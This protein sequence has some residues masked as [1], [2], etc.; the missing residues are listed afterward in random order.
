MA[1]PT[2]ASPVDPFAALTEDEEEFV[3]CLLLDFTPEQASKSAGFASKF[4]QGILLRRPHVARAIRHAADVA[5]RAARLV[6]QTAIDD[7]TTAGKIVI[8]PKRREHR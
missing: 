7:Q 5:A 8:F 6:D 1:K 2:Q 4:D 3:H